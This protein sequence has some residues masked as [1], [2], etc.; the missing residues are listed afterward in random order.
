[1][2]HVAPVRFPLAAAAAL[3]LVALLALLATPAAVAAGVK[4]PMS[5]VNAQGIDKPLGSI[6][7]VDTPS[8]LKL[9]PA[10]RNL[11]A[12]E[13][14]FHVHDK[15]S[16]EA[17]PDGDQG[18]AMTPA[19]GAGGHFD[20]AKTGHHAGPDGE[21]HRGDLPKLTVAAN[22]KATKPVVAPHL[23]LADLSGHAVVIHAG[24]DNYADEPKL[25][26]GGGR[27]ACGVVP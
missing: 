23:K 14:G 6:T 18:G 16:C 5:S 19:L 25:G 9:T 4:F 2:P 8:G 10:L 11:P 13:H 7:A 20:P 3:A 12:G 1:M 21:G 15:P 26:G 22:G 27:I 24:G 17:A